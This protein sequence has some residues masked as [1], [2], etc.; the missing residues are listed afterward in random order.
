M[1]EVTVGLIVALVALAA[2][3]QLVTL[4]ALQRR[5]AADLR[6]GTLAAGNAMEQIAA[7]PWE[8]LTPDGAADIELPAQLG[9]V[10]DDPRLSI[11]VTPVEE[12]PAGRRID[13]QLDWR[14][15]AGNRVEPVRL[16]AWRHEAANHE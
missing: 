6:A 9:Q 3:S 2:V 11:R 13:L 16:T 10:L 12:T 14:D 1:V 7:L 5:T 15:R 4:I 8:R